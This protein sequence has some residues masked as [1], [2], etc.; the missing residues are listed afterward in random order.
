[1]KL[2]GP[3]FAAVAAR[4]DGA[5]RLLGRPVRATRPT[6]RRSA[7]ATRAFPSWRPDRRRTTG[8]WRKR[9]PN[10]HIKWTKF[11]SGADVNTAFIAKELRLRRARAPA[12]SRGGLLG[13]AEHP[14]QGRVRTRRRGRQRGAGGPQRAVASTTIAE[15]QRQADRHAVRLDG[16]LQPVGRAVAERVVRQRCSAGRSA[17]AGDPGGV[18]ARRH[19]RRLHL[20]ADAATSCARTARI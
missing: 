3:C 14:L 10:Y 5:G 19:R 9:C 4:Y 13:A 16:A 11:D 15:L 7:L 12:R 18:G 20:A 6:N 2:Q 1:M 8:G 17:A